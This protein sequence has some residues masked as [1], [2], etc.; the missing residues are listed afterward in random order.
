MGIKWGKP[1]CFL[2]LPRGSGAPSPTLSLPQR[3]LLQ[4][5][6]MHVSVLGA[7]MA[8]GLCVG[9]GAPCSQGLALWH[10]NLTCVFFCTIFFNARSSLLMVLLLI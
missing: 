6:E 3:L 7:V 5:A 4:G 2:P 1:Q 9:L 8:A 10:S